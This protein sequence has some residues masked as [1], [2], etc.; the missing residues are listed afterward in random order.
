MD[1]NKFLLLVIVMTVAFSQIIL[2]VV[3]LGPLIKLLVA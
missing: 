3:L 1:L 2:C